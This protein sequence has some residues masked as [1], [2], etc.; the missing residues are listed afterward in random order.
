MDTSPDSGAPAIPGRVVA[1]NRREE[2]AGSAITR[3]NDRAAIAPPGNSR[4]DRAASGGPAVRISQDSLMATS[5]LMRE[6]YAT[7]IPPG[8]LTRSI[9]KL[10]HRSPHGARSNQSGQASVNWP[11]LHEAGHLRVRA[12][13]E[14]R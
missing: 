3:L 6:P 2:T 11:P 13:R 8:S 5:W 14:S 10:G 7:T 4:T 1:T 12:S 9:D